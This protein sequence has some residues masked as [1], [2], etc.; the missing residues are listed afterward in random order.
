ME[1]ESKASRRRTVN[2]RIFIESFFWRF[3]GTVSVTRNKCLTKASM[4][5]TNRSRFPEKCTL[6]L[7]LEIS[8]PNRVDAE[9]T[10]LLVVSYQKPHG[11]LIVEPRLGF[12]GMSH[13]TRRRCFQPLKTGHLFR[14][15]TTSSTVVFFFFVVFLEYQK[16]CL[17][18][19]RAIAALGVSG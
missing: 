19:K 7:L 12:T 5:H 11:R 6:M 15:Q 9:N 13:K 4:N 2:S 8:I 16:C 14:S 18:S 1:V 17:N 3:F 10:D